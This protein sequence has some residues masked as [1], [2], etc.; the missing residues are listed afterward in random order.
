MFEVSNH[1]NKTDICRFSPVHLQPLTDRIVPDDIL[2]E[3][4]WSTPTAR[5]NKY[6]I[7]TMP[8]IQQQTFRL[9]FPISK[10]SILTTLLLI[11]LLRL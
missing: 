11:K 10:V 9:F 8:E 1:E 6:G 7:D 5:R 3:P 2:F 4:N